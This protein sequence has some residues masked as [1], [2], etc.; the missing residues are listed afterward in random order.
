MRDESHGFP[1]GCVRIEG[2]RTLQVSKETV[3]G[4]TDT[5]LREGQT[6]LAFDATRKKLTS[7]MIAVQEEGHIKVLPRQLK[8]LSSGDSSDVDFLSALA[9][10][11]LLTAEKQ[12]KD[13][14]SSSGSRNK[15]VGEKAQRKKPTVAGAGPKKASAKRSKVLA[16]LVVAEDCVH[17]TE[18]ILKWA[19][20]TM[21]FKSF[22]SESKL[23]ATVSNLEK[24]FHILFGA[25]KSTPPCHR[26]QPAAM[27]MGRG[28]RG[29]SGET[30]TAQAKQNRQEHNHTNQ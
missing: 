20:I 29:V 4:N 19:T 26:A 12:K 2:F 18:L 6:G 30:I 9:G 1:V 3:L 8:R 17:Q 15:G 25:T 16:E 21:Q 14:S 24:R 10:A 28:E 22:L 13:P 5:D 11:D 23:T 7:P 27:P